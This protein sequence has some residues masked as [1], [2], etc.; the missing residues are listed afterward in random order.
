MDPELFRKHFPNAK[1]V[2]CVRDPCGS[3]PSFVDLC[4]A[5]AKE[6]VPYTKQFGMRMHTLFRV[7]TCRLF[8]RI[9]EYKGDDE[10]IWLD[11]E[12]WKNSGVKQLEHFW[13]E[14]GWKFPAEASQ[15]ALHRSE[16]HKNRP[17]SFEVVKKDFIK[18]ELDETF[19]KCV[20]R[21]AEYKKSKG[22]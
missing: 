15:A 8:K 14:L 12:D 21:C 22:I 19:L 11:F 17:E 18:S 2:F 7:S 3:V 4:A 10:T 13:N 9:A 6:E 16:S 1:V 20:K 5:V